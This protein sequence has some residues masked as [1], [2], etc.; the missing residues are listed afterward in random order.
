MHYLILLVM[1]VSNKITTQLLRYNH[2]IVRGLTIK[3]T[4]SSRKSATYVITEYHSCHLR[5][6][7]LGKLCTDASPTVFS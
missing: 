6:T 1:F 3:Y 7:P 4:N 5:R 2:F